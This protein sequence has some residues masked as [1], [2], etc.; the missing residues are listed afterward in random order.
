MNRA[1][2]T[3]VLRDLAGANLIAS[4]RP[5]AIEAVVDTWSRSLA[6][7]DYET[8]KS[9]SWAWVDNEDRFPTLNQ[10]LDAVQAENRTRAVQVAQLALPPTSAERRRAA[11]I[12]Q[13]I[14]AVTLE[15]EHGGEALHQ[16]V[17]LRL[18]EQG[19]D[20]PTGLRANVE[21]QGCGDDGMV[22]YDRPGNREAWRPCPDCNPDGALR[23]AEGHHESNHSCAA[24]DALRGKRQRR[25]GERTEASA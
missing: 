3:R 17:M 14:R 5:E 22:R 2:V 1:E 8:A 16:E 19:I 10:F 23:W 15:G 13:T 12:I 21:C 25:S 24:C 4:P 9:A 11:Q 20:V 18:H 7:Y 6:G